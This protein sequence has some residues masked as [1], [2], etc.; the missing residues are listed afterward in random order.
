MSICR[1]YFAQTIRR[2]YKTAK[3]QAPKD[4]ILL[5]DEESSLEGSL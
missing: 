3:R 4:D 2:L 5:A 1:L